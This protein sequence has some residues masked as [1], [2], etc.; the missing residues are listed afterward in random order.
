MNQVFKDVLDVCVVVYL[1]DILIYSDDSDEHLKHVREVLRRL[2]ANNLYVKVEGCAFSVD[3]TDFL[4]FLI[5]PNDL[6]MDTS[7]NKSSATGRHLE[8]VRTPN[9]SWVSQTS[10]NGLLPCTPI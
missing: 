4:G 10:T 6:R 2:H 5:G 3:T 7:K 9:C 8:K 1:D